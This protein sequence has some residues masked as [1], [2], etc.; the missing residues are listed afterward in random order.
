M[1]INPNAV[2]TA[3]STV[4]IA[5]L[6]DTSLLMS[7]CSFCPSALIF[8]EHKGRPRRNLGGGAND[9]VTW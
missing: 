6:L 2:C 1:R 8:T 3:L 4:N 7:L 5:S 9:H